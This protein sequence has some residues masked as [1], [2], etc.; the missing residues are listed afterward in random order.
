MEGLKEV[1]MKFFR[2]VGLLL[3]LSAVAFP[4]TKDL[5]MGA[6][7]NEN[8]PII[9]VIDASLADMKIDSPYVMFMAFMGGKDDVNATISR[10]DVVMVYGGQEYKMPSI[11]ELREK[12]NG[13]VNDRDLYRKLG[14]EGVIASA[15]RFYQFRDQYDFFP[16]LGPRGKLA[17]E[18]GSVSGLI[19]FKT[20]LYF[21]NPG[22]KKGDQ[23]LFKVR[24]KANPKLT[25]ECAVV[26]K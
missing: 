25:G 14:K 6:F 2:F 1:S 19:G 7:S 5:G 17:G 26:L 15:V 16:V 8:G 4:Q 13:E 9:L 11:K 10:D 21:K 12:Y 18:E 22:F 20:R 24:D 23:I 3:V